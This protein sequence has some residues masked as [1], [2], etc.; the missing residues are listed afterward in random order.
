MHRHRG[1]AHQ[2]QCCHQRTRK[3]LQY[4]HHLLSDVIKVYAAPSFLLLWTTAT[5]KLILACA[6]GKG[7]DQRDDRWQ[8]KNRFQLASLPSGVSS[9]CET[10]V[11]SSLLPSFVHHSASWKRHNERKD[12]RRVLYYTLSLLFPFLWHKKQKMSA[13]CDVQVDVHHR[14]PIDSIHIIPSRS[15]RSGMEIHKYML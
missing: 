3:I 4:R 2:C 15:N 7:S 13:Y 10:A 8:W 9:W 1:D 12:K 11:V 6:D 5:S 14:L